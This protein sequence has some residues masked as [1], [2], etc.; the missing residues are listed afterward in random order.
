MKL[1]DLSWVVLAGTIVASPGDVNPI[2]YAKAELEHKPTLMEK[3]CHS[4]RDVSNIGLIKEGYFVA[5]GFENNSCRLK[6]EKIPVCYQESYG[7]V[8]CS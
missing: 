5:G 2:S 4:L 3:F 7:F 6:I 1:K 8:K